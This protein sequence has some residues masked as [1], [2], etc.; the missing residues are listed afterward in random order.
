MS[1]PVNPMFKKIPKQKV[2]DKIFDQI[3]DLI[4]SGRLLPGEKIPPEM[5]L[6]SLFD[7]SRSSVREAVLRLECLGFV[8][9][10]H[11]EGTFVK[12][13]TETPVL[14]YMTEM[15]QEADF[16]EG[17]MEIRT[18][19][20]VWAART[21]AV[22]AEDQEIRELE[23][24]IA[25]MTGRKG[26]HPPRFKSNVSLHRQIA[27]ASHNPF[28]VHM[29]SSILGWIGKVTDR[30]YPEGE[31]FGTLYDQ[32]TSQHKAIVDAIAARNPDDAARAMSDH[33][34][35]T[36]LKIETK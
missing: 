14:D 29:M 26:S 25:S 31:P 10:R 34:S 28:L 24:I 5:E 2:S 18:V 27:V 19:L 12:S 16:L 23:N 4:V 1:G 11:G 33:L 6:M 8:S 20:E 35:F 9:H 30:I 7:V 22:R 17:L 3:K 15:A 36:A 13:A 21:A 32:I